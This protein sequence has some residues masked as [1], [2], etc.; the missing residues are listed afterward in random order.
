MNDERA[1]CFLCGRALGAKV[2]WHHPVPKSRGGRE[3]VPVHPICHRM[4]HATLGNKALER[5]YATADALR[6]HPD[7]ARFIVWVRGKDPDFQAPT[8]RPKS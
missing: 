2:Q 5:G 8:R 7:I 4:I 3:T 1:T 6:A